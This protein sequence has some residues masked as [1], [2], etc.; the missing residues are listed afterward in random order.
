[1]T[2]RSLLIAILFTAALL[3]GIRGPEWIAMLLIWF[4]HALIGTVPSAPVVFLGRRRVHW[5]ATDLLA[6]TLPFAVWSALVQASSRGKTLSNLGEP[7]LFALA[8]PV[9]ALLR[10]I[11]GRR[12]DEKI[13]SIVLVAALCLVAAAV[14]CL[15]PS[16]PE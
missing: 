1:M 12:T 7:F 10:V 8:I 16:L 15:T 5:R 2:T 14:Y 3:A 11:A 9:A 13:T 4:V 6:L